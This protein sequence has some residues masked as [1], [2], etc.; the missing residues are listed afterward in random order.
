MDVST[1]QSRYALTDEL[2]RSFDENGYLTF[3]GVIDA[4]KLATLTNELLMAYNRERDSGRLFDGGGRVS[5]HLNCF[6]GNGSRFV[7][8]TLKQ[9]GIFDVVRALSPTPLRAPNVGCNFNLP[10][11]Y[12]QNDHVDG[13]PSR[14]FFVVNVAPV[15]TDLGNGAMEVL[16]KTHLRT[17]PYWK[18]LLEYPERRRVCLKQGDV[19]IRVSTLWHRGMPN[20]SNRARPMLAF[21]WEDGG[22]TLDDPYRLYEGAIKFLPNRYGTD[23]ASRIRERAFSVSPRVGTAYLALRSLF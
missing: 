17:L 23:W 19:L 7:Y 11:S 20:K 2:R 6:P 5:G 3:P 12:E 14:P 9:R 21:T 1:N 13:D 10:G 16:A 18:L 4:G 15:D 8:E 22:S